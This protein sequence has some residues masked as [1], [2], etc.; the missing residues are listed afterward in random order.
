MIC[1]SWNACGLGNDQTHSA[2]D[3]LCVSHKPDWV[4]IYEPKILK[5]HLPRY[6]LK[7]L[8]LAFFANNDHS[9]SLPNIWVLCKPH[10]ASSAQL[11]GSSDQFLTVRLVGSTLVFVHASNS[12][13]RRHCLWSDLCNI[14]DP[15]IC[16]IG[17][18]NVVLGA[19]ER[20]SD[21]LA[22][23]AP[24]DDFREFISQRDL[25]DIEGIK[26]KY[27]WVT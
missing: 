3:N 13:I 27:T 5:E 10:L 14:H 12:Y 9:H 4:A 8:N 16:V 24:S 21:F 22:H 1:I 26:N 17:D 11:I 23:A 19:Y 25:F 6:F 20:S 2:L 7:K 18:F 15:S